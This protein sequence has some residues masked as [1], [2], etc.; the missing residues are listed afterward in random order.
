MFRRSGPDQ[1]QGFMQFKAGPR[2]RGHHAATLRLIS[3]GRFEISKDGGRRTDD[4]GQ[5]MRR[6]SS[7][8]SSHDRT[9][10]TQRNCSFF[11]IFVLFCGY[12]RFGCGWVALWSLRAFLAIPLVFAS[13]SCVSHA[14]R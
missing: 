2:T 10:R 8:D 7:A 5:R 9:Q 4:G 3:D 11:E 13:R 12:F 1:V 14:A 6:L